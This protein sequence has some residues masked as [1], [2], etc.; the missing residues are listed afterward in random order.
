MGLAER[1]AVTVALV[2]GVPETASVWDL[3]VERLDATGQHRVLRLSPPGFGAPVPAGWQATPEAYR[4]WLVRQLEKLEGQVHLVGHDWGGG[5]VVNV[6][7]TR[8]DL[9]SS[10]CSDVVGLFDRD[11]VWHDLATMWRTPNEGEAAIDAL[12]RMPVAARAEYLADRGMA[13]PVAGRVAEGVDAAMGVCILK[14]YRASAQ[15]VMARLGDRLADA[16]ARPGLAL[17]AGEDLMVGTDE[18]R[19][20]AA[21]RAGARTVVLDGLGHW[22]MTQDPV[23]AATVLLDFWATV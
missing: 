1:V 5:H 13:E 22:W 16:A 18:Q 19:H 21:T 20:R 4:L 10:W 6:A 9:V 12:V 23:R 14:L 8:P 15:P 7:M 3:V 17:I 2:H 11:Y